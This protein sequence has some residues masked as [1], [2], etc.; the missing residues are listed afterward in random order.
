MTFHVQSKKNAF[1]CFIIKRCFV[2]I[3]PSMRLFFFNIHASSNLFSLVKIPCRYWMAFT[4]YDRIK[5]ESTKNRIKEWI[6]D[7]SLNAAPFIL[8]WTAV[9]IKY[10]HF[11]KK[12][13]V[14]LLN[15]FLNNICFNFRLK[16]MLVESIWS[17]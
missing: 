11:N 7:H 14:K 8:I 6:P 10:R 9:K 5:G 1:N 2:I 15:A 16:K 4:I 3:K 17:E 13:P 12:N